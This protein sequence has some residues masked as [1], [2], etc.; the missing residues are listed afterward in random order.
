MIE[1]ASAGVNSFFE[2][3]GGDGAYSFFL[4]HADHKRNINQKKKIQLLLIH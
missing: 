4:L 1:N 2:R 3:Q